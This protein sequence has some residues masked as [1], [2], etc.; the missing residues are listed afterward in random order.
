MLKA[1]NP[2]VRAATRVSVKLA[3]SAYRMRNEEGLGVMADYRIYCLGRD[4]SIGFAQWFEAEND[5]DAVTRAYSL[6]PDA[7]R[8]EV[9]ERGRLIATIDA[10]TR[11]IAAS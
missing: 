3:R 7:K 4:G 2:D 11:V 8:C 1:C 9:W 5:D 10:E 6:R